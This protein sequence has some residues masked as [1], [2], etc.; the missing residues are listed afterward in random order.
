MSDYVDANGEGGSYQN[1]FRVYKQDGKQCQRC[2][3]VIKK[4]SWEA[5][6]HIIAPSV[7]NDF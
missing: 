7:R 5:G 2:K 1:H 3:S 6:E 4:L